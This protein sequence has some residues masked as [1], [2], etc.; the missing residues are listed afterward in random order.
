MAAGLTAARGLAAQ[1]TPP[2]IVAVGDSVRVYDPVRLEGAVLR[3]DPGGLVLRSAID[4][5]VRFERADLGRFEIY[6]GFLPRRGRIIEGSLMGLGL[7]VVGMLPLFNQCE[8]SCAVTGV[9]F[10]GGGMALLGG[11]IGGTTAG[12]QWQRAR[13]PPMGTV[14]PPGGSAGGAAAGGGVRITLI[15]LAL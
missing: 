15:R 6:A 11:V 7:G 4:G 5:E 14:E 3:A 12:P 13:L 9:A 2:R 10:L 1:P 8:S